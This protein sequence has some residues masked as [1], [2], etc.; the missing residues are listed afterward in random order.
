MSIDERM[1]AAI[2][3][4]PEIERD[5][6]EYFTTVENGKTGSEIRRILGC[7]YLK[8]REICALLGHGILPRS[9]TRWH[10]SLRDNVHTFTNLPPIHY[11]DPNQLD[12]VVRQQKRSVE[13]TK[14][15]TSNKQMIAALR[16]GADPVQLMRSTK[17]QIGALLHSAAAEWDMAA[18]SYVFQQSTESMHRQFPLAS[19]VD[20]LLSTTQDEVIVRRLIQEQKNLFAMVPIGTRLSFWRE[21]QRREG[22]VVVHHKNGSLTVQTNEPMPS[23]IGYRRYSITAAAIVQ[24]LERAQ[25]HSSAE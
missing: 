4:I 5:G 11:V 18:A 24:I 1:N 21:Q 8:V 23:G 7:N 10:S 15:G 2:D 9:I 25:E 13:S 22:V 14:E 12:D 6:W 19:Q 3:L 17:A 16:L 20:T